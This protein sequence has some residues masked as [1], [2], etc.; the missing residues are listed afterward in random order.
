MIDRA[1]DL[2]AKTDGNRV[3]FLSGGA[4]SL[5]VLKLC[6]EQFETDA[7]AFTSDWT[8]EQMKRLTQLSADWNFTLYTFPP[9][10]RFIVP[11]GDSFA[12]VDEYLGALPVVRDIE[13]GEKCV[14]ELSQDRHEG[15]WLDWATVFTGFKKSDTHEVTGQTVF[16]K[17]KI[18]K[19]G[20]LTFVSPL[21]DFT[22]E[23]I[24]EA[25]EM[26]DISDRVIENT[27]E[28]SACAECLKGKEVYCPVEQKRIAPKIWDG[29]AMRNAF[30]EKYG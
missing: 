6:L 23:D 22:G 7:V 4:D 24:K 12:L 5:I 27:G 26:L 28:I 15:F 19:V 3:V 20:N 10:H 11:S 14:F 30:R 21:H 17:E 29:Q 16:A 13:D 18:Y 25:L 8:D 2:I 1:R 9:S